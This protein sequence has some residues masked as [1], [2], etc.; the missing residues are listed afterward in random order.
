MQAG[1]HLLVIINEILDLALIDSGKL[2]IRLE[3]VE[4]DGLLRDC[5]SLVRAQAETRNITINN[6]ATG[7]NHKVRIDAFRFKQVL[8]NILSNAVK[9]NRRGG[10]INLTSKKKTSQILRI[11]IDDN[12]YG[13]SRNEIDKIFAPFERL[14]KSS[15]IEGTGIG[16]AISEKLIKLMKGK[17]GV[18]S[19]KGEGSSFWI[20]LP[21]IDTNKPE[22]I[23]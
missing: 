6:R 1:R 9:Y 20:E 23:K 10:C 16:L 3:N 15:K 12:G 5:T 11:Q 18:D 17:I 8:L 21:L 14:K 2:E 4:V 19:K 22:S 13:L 7:M